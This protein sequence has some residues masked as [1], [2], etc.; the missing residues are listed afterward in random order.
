[1]VSKRQTNDFSD[2]EASNSPA[3][4]ARRHHSDTESSP[5][6]SPPSKKSK[7]ARRDA[8]D[9]DNESRQVRF[10]EI[11]DEDEQANFDLEEQIRKENVDKIRAEHKNTANKRGVSID[12]IS[13]RCFLTLVSV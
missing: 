2:S 13:N 1:M 9:S 12:I 5:E 4:R 7:A 3:K 11:I 8:D 6:P 10:Q